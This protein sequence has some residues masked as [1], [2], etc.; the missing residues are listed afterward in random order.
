MDSK[1]LKGE[2]YSRLSYIE[3]Q[4]GSLLNNEYPTN[5]P[6]S[7]I[8]LIVRILGII[9][10]RFDKYTD[11][12]LKHIGQLIVRLELYCG[13]LYESQMANVPWSIIPALEVT[14]GKIK[15]DYEFIICPIWRTNYMIYNQNILQDF[16]KQVIEIPN[17]LFDYVELHN[18]QKQVSDFTKD[19]PSGIYFI[20]FPRLER[21]SS[22]H[23]A[24]LGHEIGHSYSSVWLETEWNDFVKNRELEKKFVEIAKS[25]VPITLADASMQDMFVETG[26]N[27]QSAKYLEITTK[28]L[29]ELIADVYGAFVF[30]ESAFVASFIF[31]NKTN[32]DNTKIWTEGY[33]SWRYRLH[34][35]HKAIEYIFKK[36]GADSYLKACNWSANINACLAKKWEDNVNEN[37]KYLQV[38]L[39]SI[40]AEKENIWGAVEKVIG[41]QLFLEFIKK[42]EVEAARS[43]LRYEIIPN[44]LVE[45]GETLETP[46]DLRNILYGTWLELMEIDATDIDLYKKKS[47]MINLLSIKGI[48]L[49]IEQERFNDFIK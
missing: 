24:L 22:L 34:F 49:S 2:I 44:A 42:N 41:G 39:E 40:E 27:M 13:H 36:R 33:L 6:K 32:L 26:A 5:G 18:F 21:R 1:V 45:D 28:I 9:E 17:L 10:K 11:N 7:L 3:K 19:M 31:S 38:I 16:K 20:F 25:T 47:H 43:R 12:H 46:I 35:I 14:F 8:Q 37:N 48:E 4:F 29:N 15:Q 30:G 23:F